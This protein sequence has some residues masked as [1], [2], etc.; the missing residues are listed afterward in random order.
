[1]SNGYKILSVILALILAAA[2]LTELVLWRLEYI[3]F[4]NPN[5]EQAESRDGFLIGESVGNGAEIR[6]AK[7]STEEYAENNISALAE[8]AYTLTATVQPEDATNKSVDWSIT[9][10]NPSSAWASG[11]T[12]T[13]YVTVTPTS[14]GAL[15]ANVECLQA[16]GEQMKITVTS[17]DNPEASAECTVDY[18]QKFDHITITLRNSVNTEFVR[19]QAN[20]DVS[21]PMDTVTWKWSPEAK[22]EI[23]ASAV[24]YF[25]ETY[26]IAV[27][28]TQKEV[29]LR[30][31]TDNN[32]RFW[33]YSNAESVGLN[34]EALDKDYFSEIVIGQ[35]ESFQQ[36]HPYRY[37][38]NMDVKSF[39][40]ISFFE[41]V[42][43]DKTERDKLLQ[44]FEQFYASHPTEP[45]YKAEVIM[46][47]EVIGFGDFI[48]DPTL[49]S[50]TGTGV[51][52][53]TVDPGAIEF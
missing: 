50:D 35:A 25:S 14:D 19:L 8:S 7:I 28:G 9:F 3:V 30:L 48:L 32:F 24:L 20:G 1:M 6:S 43:A 37:R 26:T 16:F 33:L 12:V 23:T 45:W 22:E 13:D 47:E 34:W 38:T 29:F 18:V 10:V 52:N 42:C 36:F 51:T 49:L 2:A 4:Q 53:V 39:F 31:K 41:K 46:D 27:D 21:V 15:T 44:L 17:R 40:D 11:K 5:A